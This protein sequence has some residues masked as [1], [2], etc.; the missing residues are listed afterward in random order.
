M[1]S[2]QKK[3]STYPAFISSKK[4]SQNTPMLKRFG[5]AKEHTHGRRRMIELASTRP[6]SLNRVFDLAKLSL[7]ACRMRQNTFSRGWAF[8]QLDV[9]QQ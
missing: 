9:H 7:S 2:T 5:R 3:E 1:I 6:S 8:G 4:P